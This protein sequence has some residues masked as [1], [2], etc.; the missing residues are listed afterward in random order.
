MELCRQEN[1]H[2]RSYRVLMNAC[3]NT[4]DDVLR[5]TTDELRAIPGMTE[6]I[7]ENIHEALEIN[8]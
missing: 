3:L 4:R 2:V 8:Y 5:L 1:L 7:L 6:R